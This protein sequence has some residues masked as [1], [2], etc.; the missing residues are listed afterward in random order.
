[1]IYPLAARLRVIQD[2]GDRTPNVRRQ[3][4]H[5]IGIADG[6]ATALFTVTTANEEGGADGGAYLC[7]MT[8][9][10]AH[11]GTSGT[12][13]AAAKAFGA[14]FTRAMTGAG[15]G[16]LSAVSEDYDDTA[17]DTDAAVRSI[18]DVALSVAETSEYVATGSITVDL[19]GTGV[20]TAEVVAV[21]EVLWTGFVTAPEVAPG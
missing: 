10:V 11:G 13:N 15:S 14:R 18:G 12:T 5:K 4:I 16:V 21:V 2:G 8:A 1:M 3:V 20:D 7:R 19:T 17:A 6:V 9:L